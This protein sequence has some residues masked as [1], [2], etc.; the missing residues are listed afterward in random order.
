MFEQ[1]SSTLS[2]DEHGVILDKIAG[3]EKI[4]SDELLCG[5]LEH[6]GKVNGRLCSLSHDVMLRIVIAI[7]LFPHLAIRQ[8]FS[9]CKKMQSGLI[10]PCRSALAAGRVRLGLEPLIELFSRLCKPKGTS[11]TIGAFY[12]GFRLM[13]ID[14]CI[15]DAPDSE[16]NSLAFGRSSGSRG[17]AAFPQVRK[18]SLVE[19]GTHMEIAMSIG[20]WA[21]S[22][23]ALLEQVWDHLPSD[24]LL[25]MD[26]GLFS[27]L[28]WNSLS[29][30][31]QLL[32]RVSNTLTLAP[33]EPLSDGS[34]L[35][36]I[37]LDSDA[38]RR[39]N[40]SRSMTVRVIEY[41]I[42]DPQRTGHQ[43][44]HRLI[45]TL[46]DEVLYPAMELIELYHVRWEQE[47]FNDEQ[48]THQNPIRAEKSAQLRSESP[49]GVRQ[50]LYALSIAHYVTR[51]M[52]L[53]A[54][55]QSKIAPTS[56][57]FTSSFRMI[58]NRLNEL[59]SVEEKVLATWYSAMLFEILTERL[60]PR[61]NRINPRVIKRK[62]SKW[63][64]KGPQH[65][66]IKPLSKTFT[67]AVVMKT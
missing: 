55:H 35:A 8:V 22:E 4:I 42:D 32:V 29:K 25:M 51:S 41:T 48:K 2:S 23:R 19:L 6:C 5:T 65:R 24:S 33:I 60:P 37:Y 15:Y 63:N 3:L 1:G 12:K 10:I 21:T 66:R 54:A 31:V 40:V 57:S 45:T 16:A 59:P 30:R 49:N 47:L 14:G 50:E 13:G 39:N 7:G 58:Q 17:Q 56:L 11:E 20:G 26:A 34:Y 27:F 62:M 53:D 18:V 64:K 67:Q 61:R 46:M 9:I 38:K 43:I 44:R 36:R 28:L 52:M